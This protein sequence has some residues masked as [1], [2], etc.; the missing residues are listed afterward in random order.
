[1]TSFYIR[2]LILLTGVL[3]KLR[4]YNYITVYFFRNK[5]HFTFYFSPF[6]IFIFHLPITTR[7]LIYVCNLS[8]Q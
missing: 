1:M 5:L 2:A 6:L 4:V 8:Q 3:F 7:E